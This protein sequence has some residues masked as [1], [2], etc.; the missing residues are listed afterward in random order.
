MEP[1]KGQR[2]RTLP[3]L[4]GNRRDPIWPLSDGAFHEECFAAHPLADTVER[5][6]ALLAERSRPWPPDCAVCRVRIGS[7]DDHFTFGLLTC[8]PDDPLYALNYL[9]LHTGCLRQ[10]PELRWVYERLS[11]LQD[12]GAWDGPDLALLLPELRPALD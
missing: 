1:G 5:L 11:E 9:Q 2:L 12:S 4:G 7:P 6:L 3:P 10:L 8:E